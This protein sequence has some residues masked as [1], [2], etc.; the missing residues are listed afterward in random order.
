[1]SIRTSIYN[2]VPVIDD[3]VVMMG[4]YIELTLTIGQ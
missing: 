3:R 2:W 4:L 1:M